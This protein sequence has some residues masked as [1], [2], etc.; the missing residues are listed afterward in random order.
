MAVRYAID[1]YNELPRNGGAVSPEEI[2][3]QTLSSHSRLLNAHPWGCVG[4]TLEP[5]LRGDGA[6]LPKW[7]P[8]TRRGQFMGF[9]PVHASTVGLMRNLKTQTI[10]P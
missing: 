6:K 9:S 1:I 10:T 5:T 2:Y 7:K 8:K 4:Y 3:A